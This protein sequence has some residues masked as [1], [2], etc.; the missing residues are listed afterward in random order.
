MCLT[1]LVVSHGGVTA[2]VDKGRA[3]DVIYLDLCK[4]FDMVPWHILISKLERCGFEGWTIRWIRNWLDSHSQRAIVNGSISRCRLVTSGVSQGSILGL[5]L[6][7][8]FIND[9]GSMYP[10]QVC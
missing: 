5:V 7:S 1:N 8:I 4:N 2:L 6:F 9:I 10:Q 3:S